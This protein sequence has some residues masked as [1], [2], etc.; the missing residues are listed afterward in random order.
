MGQACAEWRGELG[1][2]TIGALA[3]EDRAA[4]RR[5]LKV[6]TACGAEYGELLPVRGWLGRLAVAAGP[7]AARRGAWPGRG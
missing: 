2:Y 7:S 6:C 3:G 4:M 1:V 5:H